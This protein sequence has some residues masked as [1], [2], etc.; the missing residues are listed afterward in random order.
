MAWA[1][2]CAT[3]AVAQSASTSLPA[4]QPEVEILAPEVPAVPAGMIVVPKDTM[5]RLMVL[6]EVNTHDSHVG[7]RFVL[8]VD[9]KVAVGGVTVIPVGAKAWGE[10]TSLVANGDVGKAGK[11]G[12]KLLYVEVGDIHVALT[13]EQKSKGVGHGDGVALAALAYGPFGLLV[14]GS[15]GKLKAGDIFNGFLAND[16]IYDPAAAQVVVPGTQASAA[17]P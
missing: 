1:A 14:K 4:A 15:Q 13:G 12:G 7:D 10:V 8:R 6:N 11:I 9:E 2:A 16:L 3:G 17:A 5:V